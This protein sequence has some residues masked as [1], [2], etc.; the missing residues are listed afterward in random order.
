MNR[1]LKGDKG[2]GGTQDRDQIETGWTA[3]CGVL[4]V[5]SCLS[6]P[7]TGPIRFGFKKVVE[8]DSEWDDINIC[9]DED[10]EGEG[11]QNF[12]C[13]FRIWCQP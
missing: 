11:W 1:D 7:G 12:M 13:S 2:G 6:H 8:A 9:T 10:E 5:Q 4:L 3:S